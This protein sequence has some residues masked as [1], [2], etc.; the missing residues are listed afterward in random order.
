MSDDRDFWREQDDRARWRREESE[1]RRKRQE[2][3]WD[4]ARTLFRQGET[5]LA[6]ARLGFSVPDETGFYDSLDSTVAAHPLFYE[7]RLRLEQVAEDASLSESNK[8]FLSAMYEAA[9][10]DKIITDLSAKRDHYRQ[11]FE[12]EC[13]KHTARLDE[14]LAAGLYMDAIMEMNSTPEAILHQIEA[15]DHTLQSLHYRREL[16]LQ[17]ARGE[18][19]E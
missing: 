13:E 11:E 17:R 1:Y 9:Y 16:V 18:A 10:L 15:L 14:M 4:E 12:Q 2:E 6:F 5:D 3:D 19:N 7:M 8:A